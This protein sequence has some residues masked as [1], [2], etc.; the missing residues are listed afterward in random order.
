MRDFQSALAARFRQ[1]G[2]AAEEPRDVLQAL[3]VGIRP[4]RAQ[5]LKMLC[6]KPLK[7]AVA[8]SNNCQLLIRIGLDQCQFFLIPCVQGFAL[9]GQLA[10]QT[11]QRAVCPAATASTASTAAAPA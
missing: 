3:I 11:R 8:A 7:R 10:D 5:P 6:L 1:I 9:G 4:Q 2:H